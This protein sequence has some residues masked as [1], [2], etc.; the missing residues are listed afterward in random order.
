MANSENRFQRALRD[1]MANR[2]ET[3]FCHQVGADGEVEIT[4]RKLEAD[5]GAFGEAY[6]QAGVAPGELV[7]IFLRHVPQLYGAFFGAMLGGMTPSFMPCSSPRQDPDIYWRSHDALLRRIKPAAIVTD[8]ASLQEMRAAGLPF[9]SARV[10]LVE[11]IAAA[12][13]NIRFTAEESIALLQH[14]SGTTGLKKGV[15]LSYG[16]IVDQLDSYAG[17]LGL[18]HSD[19]VASWL[20]LYHD[21]GL[22]ACLMLPAYFAVPVTH[23]DP[24]HWVAR[25][26]LLFD[27][28]VSRGGTFSWLPNFAFDHLSGTVGRR[29]STWDLS[30]VR[31]F[32]N[33]SEPCKAATFDR[34][35]AAF[36]PSGVRPE[37]LQ[38]CYAM[39]ETVFA[40]SQTDVGAGPPARICVEPASLDRGDLPRLVAPHAGVELLETGRVI[41]GL[42]V[43]IHDDNGRELPDGRIGEIG[44]RGRFLF[45]GYNRD[46]TRTAERFRNGTYMSRDLGFVHGGRLYVLGRVDDL[47][48]INGRNLYAHEIEA[49]VHAIDGLKPGRTV[50][51]AWFDARLGSDTLVIMAERAAANHRSDEEIRHAVSHRVYSVFSVMPRAIELVDEGRLVKTS[52]GKISR[53]DNLD[54]FIATR[55]SNA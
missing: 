28:I 1:H 42:T 31:A 26:G 39:A 30:R 43:S 9:D 3:V 6:R 11:E 47:I 36:A 7:L 25:P 41:D 35:A 14:S 53:K 38:C 19:V 50:A 12:P 34:F 51:I 13:L 27:H 46:P 24:F 16:A 55:A 4:W 18:S 29:A 5:C 33:C 10:L 17:A 45:S 21:M 2:A 32:I 54:R 48:I 8:A 44:I 22:I 37:Q 52:S 23:L 49:T 15:S 20:P 40:V